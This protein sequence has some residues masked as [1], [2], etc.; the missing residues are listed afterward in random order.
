M[1]KSGK[2]SVWTV[3]GL[4]GLGKVEGLG[5]GC[6]EPAPARAA[7]E[8]AFL[9][10][11]VRG[12]VP[13]VVDLDELDE[14]FVL[15]LCASELLLQTGEFVEGSIQVVVLWRYGEGVGDPWMGI[16]VVVLFFTMET[17]LDGVYSFGALLVAFLYV[18]QHGLEF[19]FGLLFEGED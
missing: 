1:R 2:E 7:A 14:K 4:K 13:D 11:S 5:D 17:F 3:G 18:F 15:F 6:G 19:A 8:L 12:S 16:G 9:V 10:L